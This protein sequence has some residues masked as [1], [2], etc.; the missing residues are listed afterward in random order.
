[1]AT[2][3]D[4]HVLLERAYYMLIMVCQE[5]AQKLLEQ[6]GDTKDD[7]WTSTS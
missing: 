2:A 5:G 1:M 4:M 7:T 6:A 3:W